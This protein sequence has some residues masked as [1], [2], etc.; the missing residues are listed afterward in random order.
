MAIEDPE[1]WLALEL[2]GINETDEGESPHKKCKIDPKP[3][4]SNS[5]AIV[6]DYFNLFQKEDRSIANIEKDVRNKETKDDTIRPLTKRNIKDLENENAKIT[7]DGIDQV[8][9]RNMNKRIKKKNG[10]DTEEE[11]LVE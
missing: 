2:S 10:K 9:D 1:N 5:S 11:K 7:Q 6:E 3:L 4:E 8:E